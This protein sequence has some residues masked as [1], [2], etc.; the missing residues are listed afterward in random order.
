MQSA[1]Q[2]EN[3]PQL[4]CLII[5]QASECSDL[6]GTGWR[7]NLSSPAPSLLIHKMIMIMTR[8][9]SYLDVRQRDRPAVRVPYIPVCTVVGTGRPGR[10]ARRE[11]GMDTSDEQEAAC[12]C[13]LR[14]LFIIITNYCMLHHYFAVT[15]HKKARK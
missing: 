12:C 4:L 9:L 13:I 8:D 1:S 7:V 10:E 6:H 11:F 14:T 5:T 3:T 2:L 15:T